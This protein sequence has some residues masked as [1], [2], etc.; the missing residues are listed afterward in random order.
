MRGGL[1]L[2]SMPLA[3]L[4]LAGCSSSGPLSGPGPSLAV[5]APPRPIPDSK[6]DDVT[7]SILMAAGLDPADPTKPRELHRQVAAVVQVRYRGRTYGTALARPAP[8]RIAFVDPM[9]VANLLTGTRSKTELAQALRGP[10]VDIDSRDCRFNGHAERKVR[11]ALKLPKICPTASGSVWADLNRRE[12]AVEIH[13]SPQ[14][15]ELIR[16]APTETAGLAA[17]TL[18][19]AEPETKGVS[20][21]PFSAPAASVRPPRAGINLLSPESVVAVAQPEIAQPAAAPVSLTAPVVLPPLPN[22]S[23]AANAADPSP[24]SSLLAPASVPAPRREA[25]AARAVAPVVLSAP[26]EAGAS[27]EVVPAVAIVAGAGTLQPAVL[28]RG[29]VSETDESYAPGASSGVVRVVPEAYR[30][31]TS[32]TKLFQ[33]RY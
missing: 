16:E 17:P 13:F 1:L 29:V 21:E 7:R 15:A 18:F 26:A 32:T 30:P 9:A 25:P 8:G 3:C 5:Q 12:M 14:L 23:P 31:A 33:T 2:V 11:K 19:A 20:A 4:A 10:I 24:W 6:V 28:S 22:P 27:S